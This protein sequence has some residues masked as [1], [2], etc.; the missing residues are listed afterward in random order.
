[1]GST[2]KRNSQDNKGLDLLKI[3]SSIIKEKKKQNDPT[4]IIGSK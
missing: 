1:M 2:E 3:N 4:I